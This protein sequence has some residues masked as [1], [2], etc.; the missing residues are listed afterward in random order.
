MTDEEAKKEHDDIVKEIARE[1]GITIDEDEDEKKDKEGD[2]N[3]NDEKEEKEEKEPDAAEEEESEDEEDE[4][5]DEDEVDEEDEDS[6]PTPV[7]KPK[8]LLAKLQE[9]KR[10]AREES[11]EK[12]KKI[13]ELSLMVEEGKTAKAMED[14]IKEYAEKFGMPVE[15]V[16][17][18]FSIL[19]KHF[20]KSK[21]EAN[22]VLDKAA[23]LIQK[24]EAKEAFEN[25]FSDLTTEFPETKGLKE[26]IK[27]EAYKDSNLNKSLYEIY[28]RHVKPTITVKKKTGEGSRGGAGRG[29]AANA[30]LDFNKIAENVRNNVP[31]ALKGLSGEDQDK[32]FAWMEKS[33]SRYTR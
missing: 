18:Q 1:K 22:P 10:K 24:S 25:E 14:D 20:A 23:I 12:D 17:D 19:S 31:N 9:T 8:S 7:R 29:E 6:K 28:L 21:N 32:L 2:E 13:A 27:A 4:L 30:P 33:G 16:K 5:D 3:D 11:A 26:K 15:Q